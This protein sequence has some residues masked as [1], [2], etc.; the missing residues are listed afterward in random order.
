[1]IETPLNW[2]A[3]WGLILLGFISG[4]VIGIGFHQDTFLGGYAS[5]RRRMVRLGHIA[6]VALGV[7]NILC[8][9]APGPGALAPI[10][11]LVGG[12][13]MPVV[14]FLCAWR[15]PWRHAFPVPVAALVT[16]VVLILIRGAS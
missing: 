3:G 6:C 15:T 2:V 11:L 8:S 12:I 10:L 13:L 16:A 4:A 5:M 9:L 1:M 7:I 14:C